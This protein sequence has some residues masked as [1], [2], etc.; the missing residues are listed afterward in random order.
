[1]LEVDQNAKQWTMRL[2]GRIQDDLTEQEAL[3]SDQKFLQLF[4]KIKIEFIDDKGQAY[5]KY[6]PVVWQK[7]KSAAGDQFDCVRVQREF[8]E[9]SATFK[10]RLSLWLDQSP[11]RFVLSEQLHKILGIQE[12]TRARV[13]AAL[14]QYIKQNRLQDSDDR[15]YII[16]NSELQDV[17][18]CEDRI[19]FHQ[20]IGLLKNH[21]QEPR[22]T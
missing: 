5:P 17:F 14:W 13:V 8:L 20:I 19:E 1:M 2:E 22:P 21:L 10:V 12:E 3:Q 18:N 4:E 16:L 7:N 6:M 9:E 11:R 15:R